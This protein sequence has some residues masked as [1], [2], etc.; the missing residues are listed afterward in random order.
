MGK[1]TR[2][3]DLEDQ[4]QIIKNVILKIKVQNHYQEH[5]TLISKRG[6]MRELA[7]ILIALSKFANSVMHF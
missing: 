4:D 3:G 5:F 7:I 6:G 2:F 1:I